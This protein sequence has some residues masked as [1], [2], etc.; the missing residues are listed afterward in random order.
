MDNLKRCI[1]HIPYQIDSNVKSGTNIRPMKMKQAFEE[2]GYLVEYISGYG[3][4]RKAQINKIKRNIRNGIKYDFLY[5]ESSTMPTLLTEKN[6]LPRYPFLD[7]NFFKFCKKNGIKIGLFYRDIQWKFDIYTQ[8]IKWFKKIISIPMYKYDLYK[9]RS[10]VDVFYLPTEE[11]KEYLKDESKLLL[12]SEVLMPG[13]V[14]YIPKKKKNQFRK[15]DTLEILYVGGVDKIYDLSIFFETIKK[16]DAKVHAYVCC[17]QN[18][19]RKAFNKYDKALSDRVTIIHESGSGLEKYYEMVDIC[20]A[21]A[22]EGEYMKMAMPVKIFEYLGHEIPIIATKNTVAGNFVDEKQIGWSVD[23]SEK[24]LEMCLKHI[25]NNSNIIDQIKLNEKCIRE[26]HTW[27]ARAK[28]V[29][30][31]LTKGEEK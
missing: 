12:K 24:A 17:R 11:M 27:T 3:T 28:Q 16:I 23:Y 22:G 21:F 30:N 5:S 19:W 7:F 10:L 29:I 14:S 25:I 18:E 1:F 15:G 2:N 9:Y 8:N 6:H 13:C 26:D 4:E 31:D 20:C